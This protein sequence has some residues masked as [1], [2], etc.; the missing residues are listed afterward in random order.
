MTGGSGRF[1]GHIVVIFLVFLFIACISI[2]IAVVLACQLRYIT[3]GFGST[4]LHLY[5]GPESTPLIP[6]KSGS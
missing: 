6:A 4:F 3:F 1:P 2:A 5:I